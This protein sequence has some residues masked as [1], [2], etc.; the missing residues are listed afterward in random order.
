MISLTYLRLWAVA[1]CFLAISPGMLAV[2][3]PAHDVLPTVDHRKADRGPNL[4]G[5]QSAGLLKLQ[6]ERGEVQID[7][8]PVH[9]SPVWV[10]RASGFLTEPMGA[11][12]GPMP[13]TGQ[14]IPADPA[15]PLKAFVNGYSDLFGHDSAA[16]TETALKRQ[17]TT[18]HN[19]VRT[20]SWEQ[21]LDDIPVFDSVFV[22]HISPKGEVIN[23]SSTFVADAD[24]AAEA[25]TPNRQA[26]EANPAVS[27]EEAIILSAQVL[28]ELVDPATLDALDAAQGAARQQR[29]KAPELPGQIELKLVWLPVSRS[30]MRLCWQVELTRRL[31]GERYRVLV[32]VQTGDVQV[33]RCLTVYASDATFR[34]F[35]GESPTPFR[36]GYPVPATNQPPLVN[37]ELV[38]L[39][40]LFT[41][42]SPLG[43]IND[44]ENQTLG[45]NVDGHADRN[46]D[47][48][49]D[50]PR[51]HGSPYRTFD[52]PMDLNDRPSTYIDAAVVQ[53]FYW[54]NWMHDQLYML[55]FDEASGNFQKD[56]FG[57][58][59]AGND[60]VLADAQDGSGVNNANF[61]PSDDGTSPRVQMY[62]FDGPTPFRDGDL[63]A[64]IVLHECTHGLSTRLVGGGVGI[65]SAQTSGM[66][67][68]WSDFYALSLLSQPGDD[69][70][71]NYPMGGYA[72]LQ[73]AGL[74]ENYYYGIRRYPY[75]T[76]MSKNPLTFKDID[77][78]QA[79]SHAGIPISPINPFNPLFA[80][81][82]HNQGE[83]WCVTLWGA[84]ANLIQKHGF[85][86][87]NRMILQLVTDG[88]KLSPANPTFIQA[89]DA[90]LLADEI[91]NAGAN[92]GE[93]W[94]AFAKRGL[95]FS[96]RAPSSDVTVGVKEAFDL[97]DQLSIVPSV[98]FVSS[99]PAGG[100]FSP[101]CVTYVLTNR[102]SN[103]LSWRLTSTQSW[104]TVSAPS[105]V[106][107]G[108]GETSVTVCLGTNAGRL[109][110][111]VFRDTL[112][113]S[114]VTTRVAQTREVELR[115]M[116]I[117]QLPFNDGFESGR[118]EPYW[119]ST[120]TADFRTSVTGTDG[121]HSGSFHL[122]MDNSGSGNYARNELTLGVDLAGY[123][124]L[125]LR[126]WAK[127]FGDEP[128]G[129]PPSPFIQG[130]DFDGVAISQDGVRWYEIQDL[131]SLALTNREYVVSL[132]SA[133]ANFGLGYNSTFRIRFNHFD[134][135][136]IPFDG[137]ALD[138][139]SITG[140][141][142]YR[143]SIVAPASVA[144]GEGTVSDE[145]A[146]VLSAPV[147]HDLV[148][149][150]T[151]GNPAR[152][153]VPASVTIPAGQMF[154]PFDLIPGNDG[155]L[156]GSS[157]VSISGSTPGYQ[158]QPAIV[159]VTDDESATLRLHVPKTAKEGDGILR[160]K[161][162]V[163]LSR[164]AQ[165]DLR[166]FLSSSDVNAV[167]VP[168]S[169]VIPS[170]RKSADFDLQV[171][172]DLNLTGSRLIR[173]TAHVDNWIDD[174]AQIQIAD[175][176][177]PALTLQVPARLS[178]G[179]GTITNIASVQLS[180]I[181]A[182][183][184]QVALS[185]GAPGQLQVPNVVV[186]PAGKTSARFDISVTDDALINGERSVAINASA[187]GFASAKAAVVLIDDE[188]PPEPYQPSPR[189]GAT[190]VP[191]TTK[192][193]W[194][195]GY[196]EVL[197]N[198]GFESGDLTGW[199]LADIDFG[200]FVLNDGKID[201][202][203][204]ENPSPPY[205]GR[206]SLVT[207]QIG[208]GT[209]VLFQDV[210]VPADARAVRLSWVDKIHNYATAFVPFTQEFRVEVRNLSNNVLRT[211][212]LT[213]PGDNLV[214]DWTGRSFD[215]SEFRGQSVRIA[216][217]EQDLNSYFNVHLD[218]IS[219]FAESSGITTFD[220][221]FGTNA[222]FE[223]SDFLGSTSN[224][225]WSLPPLT[226]QTTYYWQVIEHRGLAST[227]GPIWRFTSR[228]VGDVDHFDFDP[229]A[230]S[231]EFAVP[232]PV[233][234]TARD[235]IG[236]VATNFSRSTRLSAISGPVTRSAVLVTEIDT[237][238]NDSVE[239]QNV[240]GRSIDISNWKMTLWDGRSWPAPRVTVSIPTNTICPPNGVFQL[241]RQGTAPGAF[242]V[243]FAGA[244]LFWNNGVV[245]NSLAVL[246][247]DSE[248]NV[249]DFVCA[250][251]ADPAQ[252]KDPSPI[253]RDQWI[254]EAI[255]ANTNLTFT[256]HRS[257]QADHND[258][259]D[260]IADTN[261]IGRQNPDLILPFAP[262]NSILLTP[263]LASFISGIW[264]GQVSV[265]QVSSNLTL[266][267]DDG[268]AHVGLSSSFNVG[269]KN[270]LA[271]E[272]SYSPDL[273]V[274]ADPIRY[275]LTVRNSGPDSS[276]GVQLT[277]QLPTNVDFVSATAS[278]GSCELINGIISCNLGTLN[279]NSSAT[280]SIV[281]KSIAPGVFTNFFGVSRAEPE[282]YLGNNTVAASSTVDLPLVAIND[283][284]VV[285]GN[286]GTNNCTF[287]VRLS[288]PST[289]PVS[290]N[291]S[292]SNRTAIAG[293]DYL[294]ASG[295]IVFPPG[296][297]NQSLSIKVLT[298]LL[299]EVS[300]TF[301]VDL[302]S[303]TNAAIIDDVGVGRINN[304]DAQPSIRIT[305]A[306]V[307]E[308]AP[309]QV[310]NA[311]FN[312]SLSAPSALP[313]SVNYFTSNSTAIA[314]K[315]YMPQAGSLTFFAGM[316]NIQIIVPVL[317][318]KAAESTE[319]FFI[320]LFTPLNATIAKL[321]AQGTILDNGFSE[322]DHF[323]VG[324]W[325]S[326][327][328]AGVPFTASVT[329]RDARNNP[330]TGFSGRVSLQ[331][332]LPQPDVTIGA[333]SSVWANPF[334]ALYHDSRTQVIYTS[335]ELGG[336]GNLSGLALFV[337]TPPGQTLSNW[338]IR[339]KHTPLAQYT[340]GS[341]ESADWSTVYHNHET[342]T[343]TGWVSFVFTAPFVYDGTNNLMVDLSFNNSAYS[344]DGQARFHQTVGN[345]ALLFR[346]D[347]AFGDP[348]EWSGST[349][350]PPTATNAAPN[351]RFLREN[352]LQTTPGLSGDFVNGTWS[353][354]VTLSG[355]SGN[356][357]L[358]VSDGNGHLGTSALF[359]LESDSDLNGDGLP[360]AWQA[361]YF[362]TNT[363][364]AR[365]GDDPDHDGLTNLQEFQAGSDPL[366]PNSAI[367]ISSLRIIN[368]DV[369]LQFQSVAGKAYRV[370]CSSDPSFRLPKTVADFVPGTG[371]LASV[372]DPGAASK[373]NLFYRVHLLR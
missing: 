292:T 297:T 178:E 271:L 91:D 3:H 355:S 143:F 46:G 201:P 235:D 334:G 238:N 272:L 130:A 80:D 123:T 104:L 245:G 240:S 287:T 13:R 213:Q 4:T 215:I 182:T 67:E 119:L 118:L 164:N 214:N 74:A 138:D 348:L 166:V 190:N 160:P 97:P 126:F 195:P 70:N 53:L 167:N 147:S 345:R 183:N 148:V 134:N 368:G 59:G 356:A 335:D 328:S 283:V 204:P 365:P 197:V 340:K 321:Q 38:T 295:T 210:L 95:G 173:I 113:F 293:S 311:A 79:V 105:G 342:I 218:N 367:R 34:V 296:S 23:L 127:S 305:D 43:W 336:P 122:T 71:A 248:S 202:E 351:V 199:Q 93:L 366:N 221:W 33:R 217:V 81:E 6:S 146:V 117:A 168:K 51:P 179:N 260:W 137:I 187:N 314:E 54:C 114:N 61:T 338:T 21:Q 324:G 239:F 359:I 26:V 52:F 307:T 363:A 212:F 1:L 288:A 285:E 28:E 246:L 156:N 60:P 5:K 145:A 63:D 18:S 325:P 133:L 312:V 64:E 361:R 316:T 257:G 347:S 75:T 68:G 102:S 278:Q 223:P 372:V 267:A 181:V 346:T 371:A 294:A 299:N 159:L 207:S 358:R 176:D 191:L 315:D 258:R 304:D 30:E 275:A 262:P 112:V 29:F 42:A 357:V 349:A 158:G 302:S 256:L 229:I 36:P 225:F 274:P 50:L 86:V 249:V 226:L 208:S 373:P 234:V 62:V 323:A 2:Q 116:A 268:L 82:V 242:P 90:I 319:I 254:G 290:V 185:S 339:L 128:H 252:I 264:T 193:S 83:V 251:G 322:L 58:G 331:G 152:L 284:T 37:R 22:G 216:F 78:S 286:T 88:M 343:A 282:A 186:V 48:V 157:S 57:R 273:T 277:N 56:N 241:F 66:G 92:A 96:A 231:Q 103:A 259:T 222:V 291:F 219:L 129:P 49:P 261:S 100:P 94:A 84:R 19:G 247:R 230:P 111:G 27:A 330:F 136:S 250:Y 203:G 124:N 276:T 209:H 165:A 279:P 32:D 206:F 224:I 153:K 317:G 31:A 11:M 154:A 107:P 162:R 303:P 354:L 192:L 72:T 280:V 139:I 263:A 309:G 353:G 40:A 253:P 39:T 233:R 131:R 329:A 364:A 41:N 194:L 298:D 244:N 108:F 318:D 76:D 73:F 310:T 301:E 141:P 269:A 10:R 175:N 85:E 332:T 161:S 101:D 144:E 281:V 300:E 125:T 189:N 24:L 171:G 163:Q 227:A 196:G 20:F 99:G 337:T 132:D 121:P 289:L 180:G 369:Q 69:P 17:Y 65:N 106:L 142:V 7:L 47:D 12:V 270:D 313:I 200:G 150:L 327:Q 14:P 220:V 109:T 170:G 87:G 45:N 362:G 135:F 266:L 16:L 232:F 172:D 198:G 228:A 237:G 25:G 370:E 326:P 15:L 140:A 188:T 89:R 308:P 9:G 211:V 77:P 265:Q 341:W 320:N 115:V 55:G 177:R 110:P 243:F 8:H 255:A 333:G 360:D 44:G 120:G 306:T 174:I 98:N 352:L 344:S 35:T 184:V 169:V 149:Q 350:P 205:D 236:N 151:S 155:L